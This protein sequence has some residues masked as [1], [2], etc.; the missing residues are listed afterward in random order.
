[1]NAPFAPRVVVVGAGP[2][3]LRA[4]EV[5]AE[6]GLRPVLIDEA[7]RS[8]GQIYRR[9][10]VGAERPATDLYGF[11]AG[12]AV[13]LH[14][15]LGR[16]G[17][18]VDH[19]SATLVWAI[20]GRRLSLLGPEGPSVLDFDAL[21]LATG[22][23]DRVLPFPGW[24]LPGVFTLGAAQI[25]LKAQ[26]VAIGSKVA[27]VGA[28]PLLPLVTRQYAKAGAEVALS[29][30]ATPFLP[31][32]LHGPSMLASPST[33]LK[34][35]WYMAA[36]AA[37]GVP[38]RFGA[39][40]LRVEGD[41]RVEALVWR[42][43]RGRDHRVA[44]DAVGASFGLRSEIQLAD[45]AGCRMEFDELTRQWRPIRTSEGRSTAPDVWLAGDGATIGG[46]DVAELAGTRTALALLADRGIAVDTT[47]IARLDAAL[48]RQRRFRVAVEKAYPFPRALLD[49]LADD[50]MLCRCEGV[51]VG[52][53]RAAAT[54]RGADEMNRLKAFT[55]IGMGRCQG[56]VCGQA[57]AEILAATLDRP[58][59]EVGRL[60]GNP[61]VKPI[62]IG[63]FAGAF[64]TE[65][66]R[67]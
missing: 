35:L 7:P 13:A 15:L 58:I 50:L 51:T 14:D 12:K 23:M 19:R 54:T 45:L 3:G 26:G 60:R 40:G 8:G 5:L 52:A 44:C 36:N 29:L 9:P 1:M 47:R 37:S 33:L 22:A 27:L 34:G 67:A 46:A 18:R 28:G 32:L 42:D 63:A 38:Q 43:G 25:A 62:P 49:G 57:A 20:E 17:D 64:A 56:R 65:G 61:P 21:V 31:K 41:G 55:R 4:T 53:L 66:E 10:P 11:E 30:D 48:A 24:T 16:L 59:A 2:A 39:T 6:A